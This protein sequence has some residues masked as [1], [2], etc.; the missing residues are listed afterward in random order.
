M[1]FNLR[2]ATIY[3]VLAGSRAYGTNNPNSDFDIR[4]IAI[5]P[6]ETY[7][8]ILDKF[9]QVVD[10][11]KAPK[12]HWK[13][14]SDLIPPDSD[15]QVMELTKFA[16]LAC[17]A[18]PSILETLFTEKGI[19]LEHPVMKKLLDIKQEF[20]TKKC[21]NAF[22]GYAK[23]QLHRAVRHQRW[24]VGE[25]PTE[26]KRS[27]FGL[28]DYKELSSDQFGAAFAIL[29]TEVD[30]FEIKQNDLPD[31]LKTDLFNAMRTMLKKTW[32][33]IHLD[34]P[35]PIGYGKKFEKMTDAIADLAATEMQFSFNFIELL[36]KER[37]YR[38]AKDHYNEFLDWQ[39]E[40]NPERAAIEKEF[41]VD[42]KH[43]GHLVRLMQVGREIGTHRRMRV[44]RDNADE[45]K[46]I[47]SGEAFK[48][49]EWSLNKFIEFA[50][51]E[52]EELEKI[53]E[54]SGLPDKPNMRKVHDV[55]CE[56]VLEFNGIKNESIV[57]KIV[58]KNLEGSENEIW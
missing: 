36:R 19:Y 27:D 5:S 41:G 18:N 6:I 8:G 22:C 17:N 11:P 14:Y 50:K 24:S 30:K 46:R 35:F 21:K 44:Y 45:I 52:D 9:E 39:K 25:V 23:S 7:V 32:Q 43:C 33:G 1:N 20:L 26:P 29:K 48:T 31:D 40:R 51:S 56:M 10:L 3:L 2:D 49:G 42:L 55:V 38:L 47:R 28:P 53:F 12:N 54:A 15:L 4:G 58:K 34:E 13:N 57:E 16:K 37:K